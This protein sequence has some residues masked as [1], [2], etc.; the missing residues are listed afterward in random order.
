MVVV[1]GG[2]LGARSM[3]PSM[4][5]SVSVQEKEHKRQN[6]TSGSPDP[7]HCLSWSKCGLKSQGMDVS[8][9]TGS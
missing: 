7:E 2:G 5:S 9:D 6:K 8:S 4:K 3:G 1:I